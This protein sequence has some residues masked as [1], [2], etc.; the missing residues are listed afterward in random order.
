MP[1]ASCANE[2]LL[3]QEI[4]ASPEESPVGHVGLLLGTQEKFQG[5]AEAEA[6]VVEV[7]VV[8]V[9]RDWAEG[10]FHG[11]T[12]T[13]PTQA[14]QDVD[15]LNKLRSFELHHRIVLGVHEI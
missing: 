7:E 9:T 13:S 15:S 3:Q 6:A 12:K 1:V 2:L 11:K 14:C 5:K 10:S 4:R 8:A